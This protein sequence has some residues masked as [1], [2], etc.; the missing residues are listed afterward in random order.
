[1]NAAELTLSCWACGRESAFDP[2][3][4]RCPDCDEAFELA[5]IDAPPA[6]DP[7]FGAGMPAVGSGEGM[8]RYRPAFPGCGAR[9]VAERVFMGE[10]GTPLLPAQR[11]GRALGFESLWLKDETRNPT[12][13]FK[14]R[15]TA[16]GV[17]VLVSLG[18]TSV[19]TVSTGNMARSVAAY[20]A[21]AG[22]EATVWV[23]AATP[24]GKLAATAVHG[25]GLQRFDAP[26]GEIYAASFEWSRRHGVPFVN[27]DSALRVEGQKTIAYEIAEQLGGEAPDWLLIPTSSG[28]NLSAIAKGFAEA[29]RWGWIEGACRLVAVQAEGCAPIAR[30]WEAG[31]DEPAEVRKPETI[32]G[33]ISNP[34]PPSGRRAIH[35]LRDTQG[36]AIA[37]PDDEIEAAQ[38][39]LAELTGRYVQPASAAGLA[40]LSRLGADGTIAPEDTVVLLLTGAGGNAAPPSIDLP[41]PGSLAD[42]E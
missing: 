31:G 42:V 34:T 11:L 3:I 12:C 28:G 19:G 25:A 21:R 29:V 38:L 9:L 2:F 27:S 5:A 41:P 32:A 37:V 26:Y 39:R 7:P 33:A 8:W 23:G 35:C 20:A 36:C 15:G 13:S 18:L 4:H 22:M 16:A 30:G 6:L 14:D 24:A 40:A 1:L 10:G 17:A